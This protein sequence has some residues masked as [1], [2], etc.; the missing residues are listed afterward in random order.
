MLPFCSLLTEKKAART[1]QSRSDKPAKSARDTTAAPP[2]KGVQLTQQQLTKKVRC[3]LWCVLLQLSCSRRDLGAG[4]RRLAG[5]TDR[6]S[7]QWIAP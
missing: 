4:L 2:E 5:G 6:V 7:C 3:K 1:S